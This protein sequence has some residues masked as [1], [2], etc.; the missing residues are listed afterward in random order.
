M[1]AASP[2]TAV[3]QTETTAISPDSHEREGGRPRYVHRVV[4][5]LAIASAFAAGFLLLAFVP[6]AVLLTFGGVWFGC[7]LCHASA[8]L[9]RRT[10]IPYGWALGLVTALIVAAAVAFVALL[11]WQIAAEVNELAKNLEGAV[12]TGRE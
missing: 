2:G 8:G 12:E 11:G 9:A 5:A 1:A 3:S 4:V 6:D 7:V 10:G